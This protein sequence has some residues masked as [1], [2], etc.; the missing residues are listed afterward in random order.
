NRTGESDPAEYFGDGRGTMR[1]GYCN[2]MRT[3]LTSLQSIAD[4][5]PFYIPDNIASLQS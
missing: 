4:S 2:V 3:E 5:A 1:A